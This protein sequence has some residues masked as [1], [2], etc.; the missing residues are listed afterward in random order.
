MN[1]L[2][3]L[4]KVNYSDLSQ[5]FKKFREELY[6]FFQRRADAL[7]DTVDALSSNTTAT[8]PVELSLNPV[9]RRAHPSI[10]DAVENFSPPIPALPNSAADRE[11]STPNASRPEQEQQMIRLIS[12][13]IPPLDKRPYHLFA[14]DVTSNPRPFARTL[15]DRVFTHSANPIEGNR[16]VTIGHPYSVLAYI[17]EKRNPADPKWVVPLSARRVDSKS[18]ETVVGGDQIKNLMEDPELLFHGDLV[19]E[20]ADSKYSAR[21]HVS[22][23]ARIV[24]LIDIVR[25]AGNRT[26][27]QSPPA[28]PEGQTRPANHPLW[29][30]PKFSMN[31]ETTWHPPTQTGQMITITKKGKKL[32]FSIQGWDDMLMTGKGGID[33]HEFPF[34]LIRVTCVDDAGNAVYKRP[35]WLLVFGGRRSELSLTEIVESFLQRYDIEHFFRVG[36]QKLLMT[37][38]Q[39]PNVETE[40]NWMLLVILA[41]VQLWAARKLAQQN[42]RPWESQKKPTS[43]SVASPSATQRDFGRLIQQFGTP[44]KSP[45]RRGKSPGRKKDDKQ[46]PRIRYPVIKKSKSPPKINSL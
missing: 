7:M 37:A 12:S 26:F 29:Y 11:S 36:K 13:T 24:N 27:Y 43:D 17:P 19:V 38:A 3:E 15:K 18:L 35:L 10:F 14:V 31:D 16:P 21:Q 6:K 40:E 32:T 34:R 5:K 28:T 30:G 45:K 39:T 4:Y 2:K 8:S 9:F 41:Y 42:P 44:A 46:K 23:T 22:K 33:M 1:K 20:V 25:S